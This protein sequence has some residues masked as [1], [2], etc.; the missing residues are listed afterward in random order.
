MNEQA[1]GQDSRTPFLKPSRTP[2]LFAAR[3]SRP[4]WLRSGA[5][6]LLVLFVYLLYALNTSPVT[7]SQSAPNVS[8]KAGI[9]AEQPFSPSEP[10]RAVAT[11]P[12][13]QFR[14]AGLRD[15]GLLLQQFL[16]S[17]GQIQ[18][19]VA[20]W[21]D[22]LLLQARNV[23]LCEYDGDDEITNAEAI[24]LLVYAGLPCGVKKLLIPSRLSARTATSASS[25]Y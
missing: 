14:T 16:A 2:L 6:L 13:S 23:R 18:P 9:V 19:P 22:E 4:I 25:N 3:P 21:G 12:A 7:K 1:S 24:K 17:F 11:E 15:Q 8:V 10:V 20:K 5:W